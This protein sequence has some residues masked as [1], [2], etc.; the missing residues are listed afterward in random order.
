MLAKFE[1]GDSYKNDSYKK[2]VYV[3][4]ERIEPNH[5]SFQ[6]IA[7][8]IESEQNRIDV[9]MGRLSG[10]SV[11]SLLSLQIIFFCNNLLSEKSITGPNSFKMRTTSYRHMDTPEEAS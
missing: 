10:H 4:I 11:L 7:V 1:P 6:H 3:K 2:T 8:S 9:L 5:S